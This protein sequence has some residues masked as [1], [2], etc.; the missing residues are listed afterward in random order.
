MI[1]STLFQVSTGRWARCEGDDITVFTDEQKIVFL[2][3]L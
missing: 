2:N 3:N 1:Y